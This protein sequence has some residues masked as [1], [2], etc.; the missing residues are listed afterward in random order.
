MLPINCK[1]NQFIHVLPFEHSGTTDGNNVVSGNAKSEESSQTKHTLDNI[2]VE[3]ITGTDGIERTDGQE[4][5]EII[6]E[7]TYSTSE[8][9]KIDVLAM[10][11]DGT[12]N[13]EVMNGDITKGN[14]KGRKSEEKINNRDNTDSYAFKEDKNL[15]TDDGR[16]KMKAK[17]KSLR[18]VKSVGTVKNRLRKEHKGNTYRQSCYC[19]L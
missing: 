7:N 17:V 2:K 1:P 9:N 19:E 3:V 18:D 14:E 8:M 4:N 13:V 16:E 11:S 12:E 10:E 5:T 15:N 6:D